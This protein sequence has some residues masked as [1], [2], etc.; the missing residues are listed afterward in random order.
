MR[1]ALCNCKAKIVHHQGLTQNLTTNHKFDN[2]DF[3]CVIMHNYNKEVHKCQ[4]SIN[5]RLFLDCKFDSVIESKVSRLQVNPLSRKATHILHISTTVSLH[6]FA[7]LTLD[8]LNHIKG[9]PQFQRFY[10]LGFL[11]TLIKLLQK[12]VLDLSKLVY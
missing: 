10:T 7:I 4:I 12:R 3:D 2:P 8:N 6:L 9:K 5:T 1:A 11:N